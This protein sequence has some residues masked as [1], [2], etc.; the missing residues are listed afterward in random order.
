MSINYFY[1]TNSIVS[2]IFMC[3]MFGRG[4]GWV[5]RGAS[6]DKDLSALRSEGITTVLRD[7]NPQTDPI[8]FH[9]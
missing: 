2:I 8:S 6:L 3:Q 4:S 7:Y 9:N 5:V 1:Y